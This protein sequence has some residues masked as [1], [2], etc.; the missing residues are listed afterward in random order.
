MYRSGDLIIPDKKTKI[1]ANDVLVIV[2]KTENLSKVTKQ[3]SGNN[4]VKK[5]GKKTAKIKAEKKNQT[6]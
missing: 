3:I 2:T 5:N 6:K 4:A 1:A